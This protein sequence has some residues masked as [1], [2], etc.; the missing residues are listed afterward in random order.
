MNGNKIISIQEAISEIDELPLVI[1]YKHI[2][3]V[4]INNFFKLKKNML[5]SD[6][7]FL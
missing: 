7:E 3:D 4:F 6:D 5:T 1:C 2:Q